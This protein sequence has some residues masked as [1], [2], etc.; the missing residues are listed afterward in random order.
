M[1]HN[2]SVTWKIAKRAIHADM[3]LGVGLGPPICDPNP[4]PNPNP[5]LRPTH[6]PNSPNPNPNLTLALKLTSIH[7]D[8]AVAFN[9]RTG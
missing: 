1:P 6:A 9:K 7:R 8:T 4:S 2:G 5:R 3:W